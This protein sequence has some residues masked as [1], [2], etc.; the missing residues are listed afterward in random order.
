MCARLFPHA[1]VSCCMRVLDLGGW[2]TELVHL[3]GE[4]EVCKFRV[5]STE[6]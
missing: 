3:G 6:A 2:G 4:V 5:I 1:C